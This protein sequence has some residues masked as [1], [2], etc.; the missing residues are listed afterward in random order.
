MW[1][2]AF[3]PAQNWLNLSKVIPSFKLHPQCLE[4]Q[5]SGETTTTDTLKIEST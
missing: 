2:P 3:L 4:H 5:G 1:L